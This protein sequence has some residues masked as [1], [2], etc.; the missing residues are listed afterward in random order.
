VNLASRFGLILLLI[1]GTGCDDSS[2]TTPRPPSTPTATDTPTPTP[3]Q[4]PIPCPNLAGWYDLHAGPG[5]CSPAPV[6]IPFGTL[7][8]QEGCA[9][10]F[11]LR[12]GSG[13]VS[14]EIRGDIIDV[15]WSDGC[16][17]PLV[18]SGTFEPQPDGRYK[19]SGR[20]TRQP[21]FSCCTDIQF[22]LDARIG[23]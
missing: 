4:T 13:H 19:I 14:G 5:T 18:G 9:I 10:R 1:V 8:L 6:P 16:D 7:V 12:V 15:I 11:A 17:P 20:V 22:F 3:T 2:P 23:F 21:N